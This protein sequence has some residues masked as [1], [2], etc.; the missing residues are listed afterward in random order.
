MR[1]PTATADRQMIPST[2]RKREPPPVPSRSSKPDANAR[3]ESFVAVEDDDKPESLPDE[4]A[5]N[6]ADPLFVIMGVTG[7]GKSTFISLLSEDAVEV[8]HGL[9]SK[10][11]NVTAH[12]FRCPDGR[13]AWLVDTPGFDD[14]G[15][16]NIEILEEF[17]VSLTKLYERGGKVSGMIYLHRITDPRMGGSALKTLEIFKLLT[18]A[19]AMPIVRL[20]TTRWN[21][22]DMIGPDLDKAYRLEDQ[23]RTT[24]KFWATLIRNGAITHRHLG[25]RESAQEVISSL[26]ARRDPPPKLAIV[27]EILDEK[28]SLLDT[29][30]GRFIADDNDK[31]RKHY[32]IEVEKL[33]KERQQAL[34]DKDH[35]LAE[36]LAAEEMEYQRRKETM[37]IAKSQLNVKLE[38]LHDQVYERNLRGDARSTS[39]DESSVALRSENQLLH[40]ERTHLEER[41]VRAERKHQVEMARLQEIMVQQNQQQRVE[42]RRAIQQMINRYEDESHELRGE[43]HRLKKKNKQLKRRRGTS[44]FDILMG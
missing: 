26:L 24:D 13:K 39:G 20:V 22:F 3:P 31:L 36:A 10:T 28:R 33:Q 8:G 42:S 37:L 17:I 27:M 40:S 18:G 35:E 2:Q 41:L 1:Q 21:E 23:L 12:R 6:P 14:T 30:A 11:K 29:A 34:L 4:D 44:L 15:R 7:A 38:R 32:E 5:F 16:Q 43:L 19:S 25:N 9:Q